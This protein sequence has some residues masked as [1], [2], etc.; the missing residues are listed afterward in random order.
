M[1]KVSIIV[2][3]FNH[4]SYLK[5]RIDS[6]IN[7]TFKDYELIILDD[8]SSDNSI[9]IIEQYRQIAQIS[10]IEYN[11]EN[12]GSTFKQ[13]EKGI[14]LAKGK[15]IW[16]AE[17]DDACDE[18]FLQEL[19]ILHQTYDLGIAYC[20]SLP[21]GK[22]DIV[23]DHSDWWMKRIDSKKWEGD[24][25]NNG[26]N[27]CENYLAAQCTIPNASAVLFK[28][29]ALRKIDIGN[30]NFKVCGDWF[31]YATILKECDIAYTI[32]TVNYHR[33]HSQNARSLYQSTVLVEQFIV[34]KYITANFKV[35]KTIVF[36]KSLDEKINSFISAIRSGSLSNKEILIILKSM[37]N[38]DSLFIFRLIKL[39]I[40]KALG[41]NTDF[42]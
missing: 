14:N 25:F 7:Q 40:G 6:I 31:I 17:S 5:K 37:Y 38:L 35:K 10:H 4:A 9:N 28:A 23:Y 11:K 22:D 29:D 36:R 15:Y 21:I 39:I 24:Y 12:S 20:K 13:W 26:K 16:I 27:E 33:N 8:C 1:P 42:R 2:P 3:N 32:K 18:N 19:V 34:M 30:I 41:T